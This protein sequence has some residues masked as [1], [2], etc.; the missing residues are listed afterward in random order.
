MLRNAQNEFINTFINLYSNISYGDPMR[1]S[2]DTNENHDTKIYDI[3]SRTDDKNHDIKIIS[4]L[5]IEKDNI[6][7][8]KNIKELL[9]KK[10]SHKKNTFNMFYL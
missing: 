5:H 3:K 7:M 10:T 1:Y 4:M 8:K 6:S 9:G 2:I